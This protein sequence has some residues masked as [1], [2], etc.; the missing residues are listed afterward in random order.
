MERRGREGAGD[1]V[2]RF[3]F[4]GDTH[5]RVVWDAFPPLSKRGAVEYVVEWWYRGS[6]VVS[7]QTVRGRCCAV[8]P[9]APQQQALNA[10][11]SARVGHQVAQSGVA[12]ATR[13]PLPVSRAGKG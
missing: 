4:V 5:A 7:S 8:V 13:K 2:A 11:V 6:V 9:A 1:F 3:G 10:R 12:V